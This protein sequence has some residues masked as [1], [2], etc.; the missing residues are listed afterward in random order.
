M[1]VIEF[2]VSKILIGI[3]FNVKIKHY[4]YYTDYL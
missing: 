1:Y 3:M 4:T 2:V